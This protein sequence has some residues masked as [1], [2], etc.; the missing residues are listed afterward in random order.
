M[1]TKIEV[2]YMT[3]IKFDRNANTRLHSVEWVE[4]GWLQ[5]LLEYKPGNGVEQLRCS[6]IIKYDLKCVDKASHKICEIN[7]RTPSFQCI[8]S[9]IHHPCCLIGCNQRKNHPWFSLIKIRCSQISISGTTYKHRH[10]TFLEKERGV[11]HKDIIRR[12]EINWQDHL[13]I[14]SQWGQ[15]CP[16]YSTVKEGQLDWSHLA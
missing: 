6:C 11:L 1:L 10:F 4:K 16:T 5:E 7:I 15:E 14:W 2:R 12:M 13:K 8:P 3:C 9:T